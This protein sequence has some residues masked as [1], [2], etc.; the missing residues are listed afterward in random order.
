MNKRY[1]CSEFLKR[2][3]HQKEPSENQSLKHSPLEEHK[4]HIDNLYF[5]AFRAVD[6]R[7]ACM[8]FIEGHTHVLEIF[9]ITQ[10]TS[11]KIDWVLNPNVYVI[12]VSAEENGKALAGCRI[13]VA[14]GRT[15]LPIESAVG[16]MDNRIYTMVE[17]RIANGTGEFCGLWNSWEIAG[18]GIGS[19][20]LG[21]ISIAIS[22][23]LNLSTMFGLCAP[24]TYRN[25]IRGGFRV[26]S[27][28]GING[29]FYYPKENLTATALLIDDTV[30]LGVT[31]PDEIPNIMQLR[32]KKQQVI[33]FIGTN[34]LPIKLHIDLQL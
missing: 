16:E 10:I 27:E 6:D 18:L 24:A 9:G 20:F 2:P 28:I 34:N 14:D 12:L 30:G 25:S 19:V 4:P 8:K 23:L 11:A 15:P 29:K 3:H 32:E 13:H 7:S 21:R 17:E 33:E 1:L 31:H 26:I 22:T 5:K